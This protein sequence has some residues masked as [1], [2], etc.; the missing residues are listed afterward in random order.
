MAL[1]MVHN[2]Y[3]IVVVVA[4]LFF[5]FGEIGYEYGR[6]RADH[7]GDDVPLGVTLAAAYAVVAL[8][9]GFSFQIAIN[10]YDSRRE[11]V[12]NEANSIGTTILRTQLFDAPTSAALRAKLREYVEARIEFSAGGANPHARESA[13]ER[14]SRLQAEIWALT[15]SAA[16]HDPRSTLT[17]LFVQT[18]NDMIDMSAQQ[19]AVLNAVIPTPILIV[20]LIV[21]LTAAMLLGIDFGRKGSRAPVVTALFAIMIVLVVGTIVDLDLP[22]AG[23]IRVDLSPLQSLRQ[24]F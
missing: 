21:V 23:L 3:F 14:S 12:V 2:V 20:L 17:P 5:L 18:L 7:T 15:M 4:L 8:L 11:T 1:A 16:R 10:R 6:R 19:E 13:A 9:L 24:L 22:Q